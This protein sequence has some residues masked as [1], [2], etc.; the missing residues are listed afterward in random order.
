MSCYRSNLWRAK[1]IH[2][3]RTTGSVQYI[4]FNSYLDEKEW[5]YMAFCTSASGNCSK[6]FHLHGNLTWYQTWNKIVTV[7]LARHFIW[8]YTALFCFF[9]GSPNSK[10]L[11]IIA[12]VREFP[13]KRTCFGVMLTEMEDIQI[14]LNACKG[15]DSK[16][17]KKV[18]KWQFK[19]F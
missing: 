6:T 2:I 16:Q 15:H 3:Y 11:I 13:F 18:I 8:S 14:L 1:Y 19:H 5:L 10:I 7:F 17:H 12:H 4:Y 9:S